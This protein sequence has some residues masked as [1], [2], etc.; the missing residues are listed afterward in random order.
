M[1]WSDIR[2]VGA[3][4]HWPVNLC[5]WGE[6]HSHL[7]SILQTEGM[8]QTM[9]SDEEILGSEGNV[10]WFSCF[11]GPFGMFLAWHEEIIGNSSN[12]HWSIDF[13][14]VIIPC[15]HILVE[16]SVFVLLQ[17]AYGEVVPWK[18]VQWQIEKGPLQ[19]RTYW[20]GDNDSDLRRNSGSRHPTAGLIWA[21]VKRRLST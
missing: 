12:Q 8:H 17:L 1:D 19:K 15:K 9:R 13:G 11:Q 21:A 20:H 3:L 6:V 5:A 2:Q 14:P 18:W 4:C 7:A 10:S 16:C